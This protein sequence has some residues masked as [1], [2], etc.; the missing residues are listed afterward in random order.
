VEVSVS[1]KMLQSLPKN[2]TDSTRIL[3]RV[4]GTVRNDSV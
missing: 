2:L 4:D 3:H 1:G